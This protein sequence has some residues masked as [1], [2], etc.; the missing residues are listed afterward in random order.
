[1]DKGRR[2]RGSAAD[3]VGGHAAGGGGA[4]D[5]A[6]RGVEAD[7][8][9]LAVGPVAG[10]LDVVA[11]GGELV[12]DAGGEAALDD[13]AFWESAV[14]VERAGEVQG[15]EGGRVDGGLKVHAEVDDVQEELERPLVLL[16]AA[17]GAEGHVR[18]AA[19]H[20][21][22]RGERGARALAGGE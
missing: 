5:E 9:D 8:G 19:A 7:G 11:E 21:E 15:V 18:L 16:V 4:L 14:R 2:R 20:G 3:G 13:E 22:R 10:D 6:G 1:M 12:A 17:G